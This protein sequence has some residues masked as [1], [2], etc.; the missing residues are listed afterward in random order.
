M[1]FKPAICAAFL[2]ATVSLAAPG[3]G[4]KDKD[5]THT[6][7]GPAGKGDCRDK[8]STWTKTTSSSYDPS[9][10]SSSSSSS[11]I[12]SSISSSSSYDPSSS[13]SSSSSYN[14]SS[15]SSSS[16]I[17][18][19]ASLSSSSSS[20]SS[21]SSSSSSAPPS[22]ANAGATCAST[23]DCCP[24]LQCGEGSLEDTCC[25]PLGS[26]CVSS[27][28]DTTGGCCSGNCAADSEEQFTCQDP[29]PS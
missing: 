1:H 7:C 4:D 26:A 11:S 12:S 28:T 29:S 13:S 23:Q 9:S 21:S 8:W 14:P 20:T 16:S 24:S 17:T 27:D 6:W 22:C 10:S 15:S 2:F 18:S 25:L 19:S 5:S 3:G